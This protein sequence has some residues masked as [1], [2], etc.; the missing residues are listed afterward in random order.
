MILG[1]G[2]DT[3]NIKRFHKS[4]LRTPALEKRLFTKEELDLAPKNRSKK[5]G[6]LAKRFAAKEAFSKA[7]GT[8]ICANISWKDIIVLNDE[9]GKPYLKI[10]PKAYQ[11]I[12]KKFKVKK[13][14]SHLSLSDDTEAIAFV[15]IEK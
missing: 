13:I 4:M 3:L 5:W 14:T 6:Y 15:I 1:I 7:C 2:V 10:S 9:L 11:F 8:G 12:L